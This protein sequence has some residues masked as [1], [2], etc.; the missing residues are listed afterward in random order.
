M[1]DRTHAFRVQGY[2][3]FRAL[4]LELCVRKR[5][6]FGVFGGSGEERGG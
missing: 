6:A 5:P 4:G 1:V 2:L 3:E